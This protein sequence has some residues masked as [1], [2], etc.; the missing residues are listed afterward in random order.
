MER[1]TSQRAAEFLIFAIRSMW[2][3]TLREMCSSVVA[4]FCALNVPALCRVLVSCCGSKA[5]MCCRAGSPS[6]PAQRV[7]H[8]SAG[9]T[10][11]AGSARACQTP[12]PRG[13]LQSHVTGSTRPRS[14][15]S[16]RIRLGDALNP[17]P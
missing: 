13:S 14:S 10:H 5:F 8:N 16:R 7:L 6:D 3:V 12:S 1:R 15:Q 9:A 4:T 17:K 11:G 2:L